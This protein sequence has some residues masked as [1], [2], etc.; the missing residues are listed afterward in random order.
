MRLQPFALEG[1]HVR[2]EPLAPEHV[3]ALVAAANED[4]ST[5][6]FTGVPRDQPSMSAY[7]DALRTEA[8]SDS[9][10]PFAPRRVADD[11]LVGCTRFMNVIW[12]SGRDT[13]A[14]VEIGGTWL[15]ASAQR[16]PVNTEAKLLL[17]THAFE[18]WNVHRVAICTAADN[19]RSRHAIERLGATFEGVLRNHRAVMGDGRERLGGPRDSALYSII[20]REWPAVRDG[21]RQRLDG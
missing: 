21:L 17:L 4:R 16:T 8:A 10:V 15:S 9:V 13:P 3:D 18:V 20:D 5:Y 2:L 14:E 6:G 19:E 7:I 11:S 1:R 12:W